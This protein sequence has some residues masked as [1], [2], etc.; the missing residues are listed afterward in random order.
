MITTR[1]N[2]SQCINRQLLLQQAFAGT[3]AYL[4]S[5]VPHIVYAWNFL[6]ESVV[7]LRLQHFK[8]NIANYSSFNPVYN[9]L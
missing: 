2:Y 8:S 4:H 3:N 9:I 5:F 7:N 1:P 6:P